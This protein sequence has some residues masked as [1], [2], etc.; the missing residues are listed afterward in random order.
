MDKKQP[1]QSVPQAV[2]DCRNLIK[3]MIPHI[4]KLPRNRRF[5]LGERL[6]NRLLL[7]LESLVTAAYVPTSAPSCFRPTATLRYVA[8]CGA[9]AMTSAPF[10][11]TATSSAAS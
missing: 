11:S 7:I 1:S 4:D 9:C 6:E 10:P 8:T 2:H 3:W 5:T